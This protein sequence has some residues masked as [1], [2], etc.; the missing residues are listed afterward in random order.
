MDITLVWQGP[1]GPGLFPEDP[2]TLEPFREAGVYLRLKRYRAGRTVS[3]VGQSVSV[4]TRI[5]QH[6][7][8]M[9]SLQAPLRDAH[10]AM[11]L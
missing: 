1:L 8:T 4:L 11:S 2:A 6:L 5:D 7:T 9:L 3:Y 10:A